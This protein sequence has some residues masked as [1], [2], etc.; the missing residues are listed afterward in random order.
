[1]AGAP[2]DRL[3]RLGVGLSILGIAL[4]LVALVPLVTDVELPS[5]FW[6]LSMLVGVGFALILA[7]LA[8]K[9]RSRARGQVSARAA[10]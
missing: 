1:V 5:A 3:V 8:R 6:A 9:G 2:G 4:A 10:D 7:G